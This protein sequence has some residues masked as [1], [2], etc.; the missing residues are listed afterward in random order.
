MAAKIRRS[1]VP[2]GR[3]GVEAAV[4]KEEIFYFDADLLLIDRSTKRL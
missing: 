1:R 2:G 4:S 3:L